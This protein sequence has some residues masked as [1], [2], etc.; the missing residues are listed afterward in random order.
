MLVPRFRELIDRL[1]KHLRNRSLPSFFNPNNNLF[2]GK[3]DLSSA[4]AGVSDF[5][6][7]LKANPR[8]FL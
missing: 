3:S 4:L 7:M 1:L 5:L 6:K 2:K 8:A